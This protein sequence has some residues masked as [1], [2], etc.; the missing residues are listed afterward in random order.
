MINDFLFLEIIEKA[1]KN[2]ETIIKNSSSRDINEVFKKEFEKEFKRSNHDTSQILEVD[3]I[4]INKIIVEDQKGLSNKSV[5]G[6]S[7]VF[8]GQ[9]ILKKR[10]VMRGSAPGTSIASKYLS[11]M[12]P[13]KLPK[14]IFKTKILGRALGR[15]V[16][17]VG[18]MLLA[19]D[20]IDIIITE[21]QEIGYKNR[22][23]TF[24]DFGNGGSFG[25]GGVSEKW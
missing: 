24:K 18:W 21:I 23:Q 11:Q 17:Y 10:F 5:I 25:G 9:P 19:I 3:T 16:P 15:A 12:F 4:E 8:L 2:T 13:Q 14:R 22:K 20:G 7:M 6:A 1:R